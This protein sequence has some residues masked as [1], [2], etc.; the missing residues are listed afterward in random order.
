MQPLVRLI[1]PIAHSDDRRPNGEGRTFY[2][3]G[4]PP[5]FGFLGRLFGATFP[6]YELTVT[7]ILLLYCNDVYSISLCA[8]FMRLINLFIGQNIRC[9]SSRILERGW[10]DLHTRLASKSVTRLLP[11][12]ARVVQRTFDLGSRLSAIMSHVQNWCTARCHDPPTRSRVARPYAG[13]PKPLWR[14]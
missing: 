14:H 10:A 4:V 11:K 1:K 12:I 13:P 8:I 5:H 2:F 6:N 3:C 9:D 7:H